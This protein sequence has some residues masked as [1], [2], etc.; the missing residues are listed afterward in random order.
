[1]MYDRERSDSA[2]EPRAGTEENANWQSTHR[3]QHRDPC[4]TGAGLHAACRR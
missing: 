1:M 4:V 2:V 3:A